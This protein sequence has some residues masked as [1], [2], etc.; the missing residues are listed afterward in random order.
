VVVTWTPGDDHPTVHPAPPGAADARR[1]GLDPDGA[2][3]A[4]VDDRRTVEIWE[5]DGG[6]WRST[7]TLATTIASPVDV[8]LVDQAT[9]V[10]VSAA[11]GSFELIDTATGR[12]LISNHAGIVGI[13][14]DASL[15]DVQ[16]TVRHGVLYA[17]QFVEGSA[18][19]D[20]VVDVPVAVDVLTELLCGV[21]AAPACP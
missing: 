4:T 11:D 12:R 15:A 10:L 2:T 1:L 3:A 19:A 6:A 9:L 13:G 17:Y 8:A 14:G 5:L 20:L 16:T 18:S 21:F 7:A